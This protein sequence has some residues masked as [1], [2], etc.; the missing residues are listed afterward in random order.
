MPEDVRR[1][2]ESWASIVMNIE[3]P[4]KTYLKDARLSLGGNNKLMVVVKDGLAS[5]YLIKNPENKEHL[6]RI[7]SEAIQKEIEIDIQSLAEDKAFE[8]SYI[9][10]SEVIHMDIEIED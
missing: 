10:L 3:Q 9:D 1:A 4:M 6:Q 2:V 7:V 8:D 5:D